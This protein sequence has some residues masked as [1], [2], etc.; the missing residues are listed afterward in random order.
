MLSRRWITWIAIM[1]S[2]LSAAAVAPVLDVNAFYY[3][4]AFTY[5]NV[6]STYKRTMWDLLLGFNVNK[7]GSWV[8]GWNYASSTLAENPGT[9]TSLTV[10]DMGPKVLA[11]LDKDR[12]W[13]LGVTYNLI[14]TADYASGS[15]TTELRG[16]SLK[17]ELGYMA[18]M[19]DVFVMGARLNWYK[20]S[21]KEEI[22]NTTLTDVTHSRAVIYPSFSFTLRF[23]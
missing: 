6:E 12:S 15:T 3:S 10:K 9:E 22:D 13:I 1:L 23:E 4:D 14:T 11:F 16:T 8:M 5:S 2:P 21:F 7:R 20:P 18:Q 17:A 19:S